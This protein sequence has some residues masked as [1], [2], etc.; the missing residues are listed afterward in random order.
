[1]VR[2]L[3]VTLFLVLLAATVS[4]A[5]EIKVATL[6]CFLLFDPRID[7]RGKLDDEQRMSVAQYNEKL[8]NLSSLIRG[9]D[10]VGVQETGG[11]AEV[12][13]L[14]ARAGMQGLWAKG[15]DT[16]TGQE[17]GLLHKL[18]GWTVTSAVLNQPDIIFSPDLGSGM[19]LDM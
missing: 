6:N 11:R 12:D 10:V 5:A 18:P 14:A 15:S 9:Y 16:A 13:A 2:K 4:V 8:G 1:M 19:N 3:P 7:H 17:V